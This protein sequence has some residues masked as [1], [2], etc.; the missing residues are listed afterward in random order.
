[1]E[2]FEI[3]KS[4]FH[5]GCAGWSYS[6]WKGNFYPKKLDSANFL[7]YYAKYFDTVEINTSFYYI[8][9]KELVNRW[10]QDTPSNFQFTVKMN[11][12]FTHSFNYNT[13]DRDISLFFN[14]FFPIRQK[15]SIFL[16]QFPPSFQNNPPHRKKL[17]Y[18]QKNFPHFEFA[19]EFR[20]I[21]WFNSEIYEIFDNLPNWIIAS[22]LREGIDMIYPPNQTKYYIRLIG[23]RQ[24]TKFNRIQ[25]KK[26]EVFNNLILKVKEMASL[27]SI[28]DIF[29]IFNNHFRGFSPAD[30]N[31]FKAQMNLSWKTF[32]L[33]KNLTDFF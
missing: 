27:P 1:M 12:K 15:I 17:M 29:V 21:S 26:T 28:T 9:T 31:Y 16:L 22:S 6:D 3:H 18:L 20:H 10:N 8:P 19:V 33:Q 5:V 32:E 4:K 13:I 11:Q 2:R 7:N 23:D 25:R 14:A 24:I 30:V